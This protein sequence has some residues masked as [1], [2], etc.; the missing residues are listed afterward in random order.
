MRYF[1]TIVFGLLTLVATAG[2]LLL[3][4]RIALVG[5]AGGVM[6]VLVSPILWLVLA[7]PCALLLL[8]FLLRSLRKQ[9]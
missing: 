1:G 5:K 9:T 4:H 6:A 2:V 7:G 8:V 3:A